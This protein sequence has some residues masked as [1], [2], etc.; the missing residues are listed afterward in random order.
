VRAKTEGTVLFPGRRSNPCP[1]Y[2]FAPQKRRASMICHTTRGPRIAVTL[3]SRKAEQGA[4]MLIARAA[5]RQNTDDQGM[6]RCPHTLRRLA[7]EKYHN[8]L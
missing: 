6:M 2:G 4:L 5:G 3:E 7:G 1:N 8:S